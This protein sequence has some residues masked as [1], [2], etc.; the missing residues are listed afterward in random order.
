MK[1]HSIA[2][3]S[4]VDRGL[5]KRI[6]FKAQACLVE[7]EAYAADE[8]VELAEEILSQM[9]AMA[10]AHYIR[11]ASQ[12]EVYNDFLI[13]LFNGSGHEFNANSLVF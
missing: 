9:A 3:Q 4:A 7:D 8:L 2:L 1:L 10:M 6:S 12:K 13:Q 5:P 11:H